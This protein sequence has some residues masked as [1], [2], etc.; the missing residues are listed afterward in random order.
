MHPPRPASKVQWQGRRRPSRRRWDGKLSGPQFAARAC[1]AYTA[2]VASLTLH[3]PGN[4]CYLLAYICAI[5]LPSGPL[6]GANALEQALSSLWHERPQPDSSAGLVLST[7]PEW[8]SLL[9][10]WQHLHRQQDCMGLI[11][12]LL[13]RN[14]IAFPDC[15]WEARPLPGSVEAR[16]PLIHG[17]TWIDLPLPRRDHATLQECIVGWHEQNLPHGLVGTP[18]C[19]LVC[20]ARYADIARGKNRIR[21]P[22][23]AMQ[24]ACFPI[25]QG[26]AHDVAWTSY[27]LV[28]GFY[29][30]G[31]DPEQGIIARF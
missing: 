7:L 9:R 11:L 4:H 6:V 31:R 20:L 23:K 12:H 13:E 30:W 5:R 2:T 19:L 3:N 18:R 27:S 25:F 17:T 16:R 10:E 14:P 24:Q 22:C 1:L 15:R 21:L 29:I 26:R 8:R 28:A